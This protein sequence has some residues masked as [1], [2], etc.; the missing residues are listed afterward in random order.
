M[1][2][3]TFKKDPYYLMPVHEKVVESK[4]SIKNEGTVKFT[5]QMSTVHI[6]ILHLNES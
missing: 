4:K 5:P 3:K 6:S 1:D 2:E